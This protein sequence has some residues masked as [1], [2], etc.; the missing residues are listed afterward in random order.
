Y[1]AD[2]VPARLAGLLAAESL[3]Q[4][5][6]LV[7]TFE[8]GV[9]DLAAPA[10]RASL[11]RCQAMLSASDEH[12]EQAV[13]LF[14]KSRAA[15]LAMPRPYD[16]ALDAERQAAGLAAAGRVDAAAGALSTAH[17]ELVALGATRAAARVAQTL[18]HHGQVVPRAWRG[19]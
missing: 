9:M 7:A 10:V 16:A 19:G 5:R 15:W 13:E 4:A 12:I 14:G 3:E 17:A 1:A 2:L 18:R 11:L 8:A 6:Q